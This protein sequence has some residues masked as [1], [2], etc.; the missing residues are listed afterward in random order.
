[1][2]L[3]IEGRWLALIVLIA[4][5]FTAALIFAVRFVQLPVAQ[6]RSLPPATNGI[7]IARINP[8][9]AGTRVS[10]DALLDPDPLFLPTPF[11]ASQPELP[12][13]IR[14]EPGTVSQPIGPEYTFT[15]ER[16]A[17]AFPEVVDVPARPLDSLTYGHV[18]NS[19]DVFGRFSR[20]EA[21]LRSRLAII[22]VVQA[23]TGKV[24]LS[25]E[26]APP[27]L[28]VPA[29]SAD[30]GPLELL[31]AINETGLVGLP[32]LSRGSGVEAVDSF[33]RTYLAKQFHLG[34][35]LPS[36]FYALRIGP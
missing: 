31:A 19:Y 16:A 23:K 34:E 5:G 35:R 24:V 20:E 32:D 27:L 29:L 11:N 18:Q 7:G 28:P 22:E 6:P 10:D 26:I 1:M 4:A 21:P 14:R 33:F 2:K 13:F 15:Y 36:G 30:W 25:A 8:Q 17:I 12:P 3:P 9:T